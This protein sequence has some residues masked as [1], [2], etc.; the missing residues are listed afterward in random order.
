MTIDLYCNV[1]APFCRAVMLL[2]KALDLELNLI[3]TNVLRREQY[4][5]EFLAMNP[6][7]CIPTLVDGD[8]VVWESNTILMYL[9]EKYGTDDKQ[10]YPKDIGERA[11]VN[12]LL[13]F[14]L[15][16]LH[17]NVS[18][19]YYPIL[20]GMSEGKQEDF[21]KMQDSVCILDKFLDGNRWLAGDQLTV[22]DFSIVISVAALEGVVKFDL[23]RYPNVPRWYARCKQEIQG[24][25]EITM[26]ATNKS[27]ACFEALRRYKKD[28]ILLAQETPSC[29][30][31]P[32]C[33]SEA[34]SK[35]DKPSDS[36]DT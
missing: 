2:A 23:S 31:V 3:E 11:K 26:E 25:E 32:S 29:S 12:R 15:G 20:M 33:S 1:V 22:A 16:N 24:F 21:R 19:Y 10:F 4:K 7:H 28:Q 5:P 18:T 8:V 6:Q 36:D 35:S 9:A 13:F 27:K 34:C 30:S 14:Q 17:R